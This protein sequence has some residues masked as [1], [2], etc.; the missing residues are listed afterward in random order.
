MNHFFA[1]KKHKLNL[2]YSLK[3]SDYINDLCF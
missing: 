3:N 2:I 1:S